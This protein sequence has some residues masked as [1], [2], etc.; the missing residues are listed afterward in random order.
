MGGACNAH[1]GDKKYVQ[2]SVSISLGGR[3]I[4]K[5]ILGK[6]VWGDVDW[7]YVA[8]DMDQ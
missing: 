1:G 5:W 2:N 6:L 7:I 8:Q 3:I 4:L